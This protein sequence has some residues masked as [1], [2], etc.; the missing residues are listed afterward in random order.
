MIN[1]Q[2][3]YN[4][5]ETQFKG[6]P[7]EK[8]I[9]ELHLVELEM[10]DLIENRSKCE[11]GSIQYFITFTFTL[12][13]VTT[14]VFWKIADM[15]NEIGVGVIV[16]IYLAIALMIVRGEIKKHN[17]EVAK[18]KEDFLKEREKIKE[19]RMKTKI[20]QELLK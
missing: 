6:Q 9:K 19:L 13:S 18:V 8:L 15:F 20:L 17:K 7:K 4:N 10:E 1:L 11:N 3:E 12:L 2:L 5:Y 16:L 14:A